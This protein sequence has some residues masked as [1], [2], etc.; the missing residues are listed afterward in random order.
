MLWPTCTKLE[1]SASA[2]PNIQFQN[3]K[4][5]QLGIGDHS[6]SSAISPLDRANK[7]LFTFHRM[8]VLTSYH[9]A[10]YLSKVA[11]AFYPMCIRHP[12]VVTPFINKLSQEAQL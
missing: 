7:F 12:V 3:A 4:L 5:G 10:S 11:N 9:I 1:D 6:R 8:C 2:I